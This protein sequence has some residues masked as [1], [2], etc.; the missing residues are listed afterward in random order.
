MGPAINLWCGRFLPNRFIERLS[1]HSAKPM[2]PRIFATA[3]FATQSYLLSFAT[4]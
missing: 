4:R 1:A 3:M 2:L